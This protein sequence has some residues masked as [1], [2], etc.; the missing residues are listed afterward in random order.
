MAQGFSDVLSPTFQIVD[1]GA[2]ANTDSQGYP[3]KN[4]SMTASLKI[5]K[6]S[7]VAGVGVATLVVTPGSTQTFTSSAAAWTILKFGSET[8][9]GGILMK[10]D[11]S[12]FALSDLPVGA[13]YAN[14]IAFASDGLCACSGDGD[15]W[16]LIGVYAAT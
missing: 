1:S 15:P 5:N 2:T 9:I 13:I 10:A 16:R 8:Q 7:G 6:D 12:A 3:D 4:K 14:C 11:H